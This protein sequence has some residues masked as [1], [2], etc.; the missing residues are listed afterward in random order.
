MLIILLLNYGKLLSKKNNNINIDFYIYICVIIYFIDNSKQLFLYT[1]IYYPILRD[2]SL[3][4]STT[5]MVMFGLE[6]P[7]C[8]PPLRPELVSL[9]STNQTL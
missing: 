4:L 3:R 5:R 7:Q 9:V 6:L 2:S 8:S 1:Y